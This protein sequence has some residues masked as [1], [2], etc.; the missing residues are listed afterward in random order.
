MY[1]SC[2]HADPALRSLHFPEAHPKAAVGELPFFQA[3][4]VKEALRK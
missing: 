2:M 4:D 3:S 1:Y